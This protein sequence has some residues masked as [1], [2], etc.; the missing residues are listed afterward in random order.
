MKN[1]IQE[2]DSLPVAAPAGGVLS[3][4]P[5]IIGSLIGI[6]STTAAEGT[7]FSLQREG[8]F[9]LPKVGAQVWTVGAKIYW[10]ATASL[11]T[12]VNTSNTL[13]GTAT[14]P[15]AN[16]SPTGNVLLG[17]TTV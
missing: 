14:A 9:E 11:A 3:G 8:V 7:M 6:A 10:D 13:I 2:G 16:P 1:Y 15:T 5:V 17:P 4:M 12:T